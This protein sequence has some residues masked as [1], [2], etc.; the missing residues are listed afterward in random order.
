MPLGGG[1]QNKNEAALSAMDGVLDNTRFGRPDDFVEVEPS[2]EA[3][4]VM[5]EF[6]GRPRALHPAVWTRRSGEKVL[7]VSPWMAKG[8]AGRDRKS[9]SRNARP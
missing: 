9:T 1:D 3:A 8:L 7:H 6:A 4:A 5:T 2:R